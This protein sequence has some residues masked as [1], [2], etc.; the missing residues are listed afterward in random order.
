MLLLIKWAFTTVS[1]WQKRACGVTQLISSA[2]IANGLLHSN[3]CARNCLAHWCAN[4]TPTSRA[5]VLSPLVPQLQ[6]H[7]IPLPITSSLKAW[8]S[9]R[10]QCIKF[11]RGIS[12]FI[13]SLLLLKR[14]KIF[15]EKP[16]PSFSWEITLLTET[17]QSKGSLELPYSLQL[18]EGP[19]LQSW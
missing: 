13:K 18:A 16:I 10:G 6:A 3:S 5:G 1:Y 12:R 19:I 8:E 17:A 2:A 15:K 14:K 7:L 9:G 4:R 11:K